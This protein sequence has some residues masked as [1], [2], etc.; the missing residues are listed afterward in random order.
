MQHN[1]GQYKVLW[2][3]DESIDLARQAAAV[4]SQVIYRMRI[5]HTATEAVAILDTAK[6]IQYDAIIVDMR[7]EP[8]EDERWQQLSRQR[9]R[10]G[11]RVLLGQ[12]LTYSLL[13]HEKARV[14]LN[15]GP[16]IEA[17]QLGFMTIEPARELLPFMKQIGLAEEFKQRYVNKTDALPHDALL[18]LIRYIIQQ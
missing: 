18:Q 13:G 12:E 14:R 5:A 7:L 3:E 8:G 6:D 11:R 16:L 4:Y 10:H 9:T 1:R 15:P 17:R 2:I